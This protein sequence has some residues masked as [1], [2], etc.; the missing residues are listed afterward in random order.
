[1]WQPLEIQWGRLPSCHG[2]S[3]LAPSASLELLHQFSSMS[4]F[5]WHPWRYYFQNYHSQSKCILS[6]SFWRCF[7]GFQRS[8]GRNPNSS[9]WHWQAAHHLDLTQSLLLS[10][11]LTS[12]SSLPTYISAQMQVISS[13]KVS[14]REGSL[15]PFQNQLKGNVASRIKVLTDVYILIPGTLPGK[16]DFAGVIKAKDLEIGR[17]SWIIQMTANIIKRVHKSKEP[18]LSAENHIDGSMKKDSA[19]LC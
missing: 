11:I 12:G 9:A 2:P 8:L 10:N 15:W 13:R 6:L 5:F 16:I 17:L 4:L 18:F 14:P 19:C 7:T 1:M 3:L